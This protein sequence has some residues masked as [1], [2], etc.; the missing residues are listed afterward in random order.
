V[1]VTFTQPCSRNVRFAP[2]AKIGSAGTAVRDGSGRVVGYVVEAHPNDALDGLEI[3]AE[4]DDE[5]FALIS[6]LAF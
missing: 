2:D 4:M 3:T 6:D 1:R 5:L